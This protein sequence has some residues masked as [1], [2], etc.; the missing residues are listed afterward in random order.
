MKTIERYKYIGPIPEIKLGFFHLIN[1]TLKTEL[2]QILI[3][4]LK[5]GFERINGCPA[6]SLKPRVE[7]FPYDLV[8]VGRY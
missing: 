3:L 6:Y 4:F 8:L 1:A 5:F 2:G 7:A